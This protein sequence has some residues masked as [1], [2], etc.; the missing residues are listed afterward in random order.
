[1]KNSAPN[2]FIWAHIFKKAPPSEGGTSP[3][4]HPPASRK[5]DG[6]RWRAILDF[7]KSGPPTLKIV[8][9]PMALILSILPY[10]GGYQLV[11]NCLSLD[12]TFSRQANPT[13]ND[14]FS[15]AFFPSVLSPH[16]VRKVSPFLKRMSHTQAK[17][18]ARFA[19]IFTRDRSRTR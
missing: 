9:P 19:C 3:L 1:M 6:W 4:R 17:T 11:F 10:V 8:P 16:S 18:F 2:H 12:R 5:R 14:L 7:K 15:R 13:K